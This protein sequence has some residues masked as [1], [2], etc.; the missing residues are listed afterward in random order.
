M[1]GAAG[2]RTAAGSRPALVSH[3]R[4]IRLIDDKPARMHTLRATQ[5]SPARLFVY[6]GLHMHDNNFIDGSS[7]SNC[8]AQAR[9]VPLPVHEFTQTYWSLKQNSQGKLL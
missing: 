7:S 8:L 3:E 4:Q 9:P 2:R 5:L 1:Q 6:A